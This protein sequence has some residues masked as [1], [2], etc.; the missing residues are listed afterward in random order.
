MKLF[1]RF[2]A[3]FFIFLN[4]SNVKKLHR[5]RA[6]FYAAGINSISLPMFN[7]AC[8]YTSKNSV[9]RKTYEVDGFWPFIINRAYHLNLI[10]SS[11]CNQMLKKNVIEAKYY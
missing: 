8:V 9:Q 2:S 3:A 4:V 11:R 5:C 1:P 7:A 6:S 10:A